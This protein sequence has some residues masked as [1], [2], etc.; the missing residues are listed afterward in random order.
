MGCFFPTRT[1]TTA[2]ASGPLGDVARLTPF[3]GGLPTRRSRASGLC[4]A[5]DLRRFPAPRHRDFRG[6][7]TAPLAGDCLLHLRTAAARSDHQFFGG[8]GRKLRARFV[9]ETGQ[10]LAQSFYFFLE[11]RGTTQ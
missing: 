6:C 3:K 2:G 9:E 8:S 7:R 5:D 1:L 10:L 11:F 4:P